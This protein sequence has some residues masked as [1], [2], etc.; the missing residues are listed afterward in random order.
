MKIN[1]NAEGLLTF[2][3]GTIDKPNDQE[4]V[5]Q[6]T[7]WVKDFVGD[8]GIRLGGYSSNFS[9][10]KLAVNGYG[11]IDIN[12]L[13]TPKDYPS[14]VNFVQDIKK[15]FPENEIMHVL[16]RDAYAVHTF[17]LNS[18]RPSVVE[19][20]N[21]LYLPKYKWSSIDFHPKLRQISVVN[22][23]YDANIQTCINVPPE[24]DTRFMRDILNSQIFHV[25]AISIHCYKNNPEEIIQLVQFLEGD[26][27]R[28]VYVSEV[29]LNLK[30]IADNPTI[31]HS[32]LYKGKLQIFGG[33]LHPKAK[34]RNERMEKRD[35]L[36]EYAVPKFKNLV[37]GL[38]EA[39]IKAHVHNLT[40][41][42]MYAMIGKGGL[43][44]WGLA[45]N[46]LKNEML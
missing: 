4:T 39:G 34:D 20:G 21:E 29:H 23:R 2:I 44:I 13:E 46:E 32:M 7:E 25:D 6:R 18:L 17:E 14:E 35:A 19:I 26:T 40:G 12:G 27:G 8:G 1:Y 38:Y 36:K 41:Q 22:Y 45:I 10:A 33:E 15:L 42:G 11:Y 16:N 9:T 31:F 3:H 30:A 24:K 43:T 5:Q 37:N 28:D